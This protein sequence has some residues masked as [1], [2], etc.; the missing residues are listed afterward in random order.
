MVYLYHISSLE[1]KHFPLHRFITAIPKKS[2]Y[3][4]K[5]KYITTGYVVEEV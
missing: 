3:Q 5:L 4:M 2:P 1:M